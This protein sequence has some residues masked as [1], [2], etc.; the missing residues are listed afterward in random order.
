MAPYSIPATHY[1]VKRTVLAV[2]EG[3]E[4]MVGVGG[5]WMMDQQRIHTQEIR[6]AGKA[7]LAIWWL[8]PQWR[9]RNVDV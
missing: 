8:E 5:H 4:N 6:V 3:I 1:K 7:C 2:G 9:D